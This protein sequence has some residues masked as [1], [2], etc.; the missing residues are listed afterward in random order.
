MVS[1]GSGLSQVKAPGA[2]DNDNILLSKDTK[3]MIKSVRD[4]KNNTGLEAL[5]ETSNPELT[6]FPNNI[7]SIDNYIQFKVLKGYQF[8]STFTT[9]SPSDF[10]ETHADIILPLPNSLATQYSQNY[11]SDN[12]GV[13]GSAAAPATS[14]LINAVSS[15]KS[16]ADITSQLKPSALKALDNVGFEGIAA[17]G[18]EIA[19]TELA[20][21]V[22]AGIAG[23]GGTIAGEGVRQIVTGALG[24]KGVARNPHMAIFYE[25]PNFRTFNFSFDLKPKELQDSV[26]LY[27]II[28]AFKFYS[29][30]AYSNKKH[31]FDYPNQFQIKTK[32]DKM[33]FNYGISV[34]TDMTV[35]YH[36]EG[37]PLYYDATDMSESQRT[38]MGVSRGVQTGGVM[39][40]QSTMKFDRP[41]IKAP[42]AVTLGLQF[43]ELRIV[44]KDAVQAGR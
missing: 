25:S 33:L 35:E 42:A 18:T 34:L 16:V 38:S 17:M 32:H 39:D 31:F 5:E 40:A 12:L 11:K 41:V 43:T 22:G 10:G 9:R 4:L 15:A 23:I 20:N 14:D 21:M 7:D 1:V 36:G 37:T 28:K 30:P 19:G 2:G 44:T 27:K 24:V 13:I 26:N 29:A 8:E 3:D 6:K